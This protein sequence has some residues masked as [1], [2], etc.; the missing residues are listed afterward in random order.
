MLVHEDKPS[1]RA[2][3]QTTPDGEVSLT[4]I[5]SWLNFR[6]CMHDGTASY[7]LSRLMCNKL[8]NNFYNCSLIMS[9][10]GGTDRLIY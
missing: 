9:S 2:I 1:G 10:S 7:D 4:N 5:L 3:I 8:A 6:G